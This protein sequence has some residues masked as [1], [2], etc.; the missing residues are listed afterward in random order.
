MCAAMPTCGPSNSADL[1]ST[2]YTTIKVNLLAPSINLTG[3]RRSHRLDQDQRLGV[4]WQIKAQS[5]AIRISLTVWSSTTSYADSIPSSQ[6]NVTGTVN[7]GL[8]SLNLSASPTFVP[9]AGQQFVIVNN[10]G[11]E[12]ITSSFAGFAQGATTV[13]GGHTFTISYSGGSNSN[14]VVLTEQSPIIDLNGVS[15]GTS[16]SNE[17]SKTA[18]V[19]VAITNSALATVADGGG[20][21]GFDDAQSSRTRTRATSCRPPSRWQRHHSE[22]ERRRQY[23]GSLRR[24]T[25]W[26]TTRQPCVRSSTP[27]RRVVR[28]SVPSISPSRPA[29]ARIRVP[30]CSPRSPIRRRCWI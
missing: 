8:A 2:A 28:A 27:T 4:R 21:P 16:F 24:L 3:P 5:M 19:P 25:A 20:T 29:M 7:L 13:I 18:A 17:W 30:R 15:A 23:F 10:D 9:S 14:D 26:P 6:L 1:S 11:A 12:A 22:L